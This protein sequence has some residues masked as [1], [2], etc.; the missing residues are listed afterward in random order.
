MRGLQ[1]CHYKN[2]EMFVCCKQKN[3][4]KGIRKEYK[5]SITYEKNQ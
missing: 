1:T 4:Q 5:S 2:Y 3:K